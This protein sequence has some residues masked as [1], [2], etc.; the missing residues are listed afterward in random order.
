VDEYSQSDSRGIITI[1]INNGYRY[2]E[3]VIN[4][5]ANKRTE[6][7][8]RTGKTPGSPPESV[9]K[10]KLAMLDGATA[11]DDLKCPP[12]NRLEKLRGN[13]EGQHSIRI[14]SQYRLCFVWRGHAAF[15]VEITNYH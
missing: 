13:R 12:G 8:W 5:F 15:E 6:G 7:I 14:N 11:W 3:S 2:A 1:D 10:R 9:T 4:T